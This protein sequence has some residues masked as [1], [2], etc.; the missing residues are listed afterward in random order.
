MPRASAPE[1][2]PRSRDGVPREAGSVRKRKQFSDAIP[3]LEHEVRTIG[4]AIKYWRQ[5]RDLTQ[6]ALGARVGLSQELIS[7]YERGEIQGISYRR[8]GQLA[9]GLDIT[10][11]KLFEGEPASPDALSRGKTRGCLNVRPAVAVTVRRPTLLPRGNP[12]R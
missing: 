5:L 4:C 12:S 7:R 6:E 8:L 10:I 3:N 2:R 1:Q 11:D 9:R